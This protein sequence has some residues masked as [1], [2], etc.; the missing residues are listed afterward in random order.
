[1]HQLQHNRGPRYH[2]ALHRPDQ[3]ISRDDEEVFFSSVLVGLNSSWP[4]AS[5]VGSV[6][7]DYS[8]RGV[9]VIV[10]P[11]VR[12]LYFD[13]SVD[14]KFDIPPASYEEKFKVVALKIARNAWIRSFSSAYTLRPSFD[15][16]EKEMEN[17]ASAASTSLEQGADWVSAM[18]ALQNQ[19]RRH[20]A[21]RAVARAVM[22]AK[23]SGKFSKLDG[24]ISSVAL[25][26]LEPSLLVALVRHTFSIKHLL[27]SYVA[28]LKKVD[29]QL[30]A[31]ELD[32]DRLLR[33][34]KDAV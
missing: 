33:G 16:L 26:T 24:E 21:L 4:D 22:S 14:R 23:V 18:L 3:V 9:K 25:E 8:N 2:G 32:S 7:E 27:G 20:E 34:L 31:R 10:K 12:N 17:P 28:L 29:A 13:A 30:R 11:E 1:M 15:G 6:Y 19:G 5:G